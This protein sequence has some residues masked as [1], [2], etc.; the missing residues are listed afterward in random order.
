MVKKPNEKWR[1]FMDFIDLKK[2]CSKDSYPLLGID[3][4]V[5]STQDISFLDDFSRYNQI[6]LDKSD[7][8][9]TSFVTRQGLFCY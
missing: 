6:K 4:L 8:E 7:Q 3:L 1:M 2:V 9:K 5:D